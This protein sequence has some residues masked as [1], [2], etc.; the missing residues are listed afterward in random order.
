MLPKSWLERPRKANTVKYE[1]RICDLLGL[2]HPDA[3]SNAGPSIFAGSVTPAHCLPIV[4]KVTT[5]WLKEKRALIDDQVKRGDWNDLSVE[6]L[7][8]I[9]WDGQLSGYGITG[10]DVT[11]LLTFGYLFLTYPQY[12]HNVARPI[13]PV[14]VTRIRYRGRVD[15]GEVQSTETPVYRPLDLRFLML[16]GGYDAETPLSWTPDLAGYIAYLKAAAPGMASFLSRPLPARLPAAAMLRHTYVTGAIGSGKTELLKLLT[17]GLTDIGNCAVVVIDPHGDMAEQIARWPEFAP[18]GKA[19][20]RLVYVDPYLSP[21]HTPCINPF[22]LG[23]RKPTPADSQQFIEAL[24]EVL[25]EDSG[26]SITIPMRNILHHV[27]PVLMGQ[28]NRSPADLIRFMNSAENV[29]LIEEARRL[30]PP[31][32]ASFFSGE[33]QAPQYQQTRLAIT[34]K[35]RVMLRAGRPLFTGQSTVD[36]EKLIDQKKVIVFNLAKGRLGNEA[37]TALG[38]FILAELLALAHRRASTSRTKR[39]PAHVIVDECHTYLGPSVEQILTD[40]RKFGICLTLCQQQVGQGMSGDLA[41]SVVGNPGLKITG[42]NEIASYR[43]IA[44]STNTPQEEFQKLKD[45]QFLVTRRGKLPFVL[46]VAGH[47]ADE[48][49][50]MSDTDWQKVITKQLAAYYRPL[51]NA[52]NNTPTLDGPGPKYDL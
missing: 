22:D 49:R 14:S 48:R 18:G 6:D 36:L 29:D 8:A 27:V 32:E 5:D 15:A 1:H 50:A 21:D 40:A 37:S 35:L 28:P 7:P 10:K 38:R 2:V 24:E 4:E 45:R 12:L 34:T 41:R 51:D 13:R 47:L 23:G 39:I 31:G 16:K 20:D 43:A 30:L 42:T 11:A 44:A 46:D 25:G 52:D 3:D 9:P 19:H 26:A 17:H 33:F